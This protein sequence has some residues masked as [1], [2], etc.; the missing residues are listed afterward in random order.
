IRHIRN[1][2]TEDFASELTR[3]LVLLRLDYCNSPFHGL[4]SYILTLLQRA[5]NRVVKV[6][7]NISNSSSSTYSLIQLH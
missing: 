6:V 5:Q 3:C 2:F 4:P 7:L 1:F